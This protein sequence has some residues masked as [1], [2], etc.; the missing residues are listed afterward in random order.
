M[1]QTSQSALNDYVG[2]IDV[3]LP[4]QFFD[5]SGK[6]RLGSE[7]RLMLAVLVDAVNILR[8]WHVSAGA[9]K[10]RLFAEASRWV[11]TRG[12]RYPFSFDN[13][14]SALGID[15]EALRRQL[16][17]VAMSSPGA[18]RSELGRLRLKESSRVQ[19]MTVNRIRCRS[20]RRTVPLGRRSA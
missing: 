18:L 3:I 19:H 4:S 13:V 17:R 14:C 6:Q 15:A 1:R 7:Q 16:S 11:V 5:M 2:T 20:H 12:D 8:S 9:R 10:R